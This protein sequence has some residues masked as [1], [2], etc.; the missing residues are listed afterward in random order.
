MTRKNRGKSWFL[1]ALVLC[2]LFTPGAADARLTR[3]NAGAEATFHA[4][5]SFG[6]QVQGRTTDVTVSDDG[7]TV[8]VSA[9]LAS[10]DT[11]LSLRNKH[12]RAALDTDAYPRAV[13][14]VP[15]SALHFPASHA[16]VDDDAPGQFVLHGQTRD[17]TFHYHAT[18][19]GVAIDVRGSATLNITDY[20]IRPPR[21]A[22]MT[23]H[24]NV[25]I[26]AHFAVTDP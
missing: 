8:R 17:I 1:G 3:T 12:M 7:T 15:R 10:L 20:G 23:V 26:E 5:A 22:G 2:A 11:G 18:D 13:L 6:M 9:D 25:Q 24:P 19:N 4:E 21:Q 14:Q 16:T